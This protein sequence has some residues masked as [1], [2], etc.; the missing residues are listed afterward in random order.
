MVEKPPLVS[1]IMAAYNVQKYLEQ[2]IKSVLAQSYKNWELL[3]VDDGS[4]DL[5][6]QIAENFSKKDPRIHFTRMGMNTGSPA[7]PRN[8]ALDL[9]RGTYIAFLDADD[10]FMPEKIAEQVHFMQQ[11]DFALTHTSY[12]RMTEDG[13]QIGRLIEPPAKYNLR[14]YLGNTCICFSTTMLNLNK[15]GKIR[16]ESGYNGREDLVLWIGLLRKYN[17]YGLKKDLLRYRRIQSSMSNKNSMWQNW[18]VYTEK[19]PEFS[20]LTRVI[21]YAGFRYNAIKRYREF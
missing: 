8:K 18:Y 2:C 21:A 9:A 16:F 19:V 6:A 10:V 20:F 4:T 5:T 14:Q 7:A 11:N 17:I 15:T 1:I 3:I 12:R 13:Q